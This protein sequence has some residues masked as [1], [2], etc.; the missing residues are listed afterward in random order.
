M[1]EMRGYFAEFQKGQGS[2]PMPVGISTVYRSSTLARL[3][4]QGSY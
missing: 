2:T 3:S 1:G 4:G